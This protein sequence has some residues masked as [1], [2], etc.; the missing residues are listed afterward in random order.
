[1]TRVLLLVGVL[2]AVPAGA[3]ELF[4]AT[5]GS[6]GK[7]DGSL[8]SPFATISKAAS[9][10]RPGDTVLVRGGVYRQPVAVW[11]DGTEGARITFRPYR[12]ERP[13][14]DGGGRGI[15]AVTIGGDYV[16]WIGFEIRNSGHIGLVCWGAHHVRLLDNVVHRSVRAGIYVGHSEPYRVHDVEVAG[17]SVYDN[18]L[19]NRRRTWPYGNWA[20]AVAV[21]ESRRVTVRQNRV[22]RNFGEG[23]LAGDSKD[24]LI[25]ANEVFD[26]YSVQI[27][28]TYAQRT[29]VD[30]NRTYSTGNRS[31]YRNGRPADGIMLANEKE[32]K[33]SEATNGNSIVNNVV[34]RSRWGISYWRRTPHG[35]KNTR[36]ANNTI[37][38]A[39][40]YLLYID[41][42]PA[43]SGN[44]VENNIFRQRR[45]SAATMV[46]VPPGAA[47]VRN[48]RWTAVS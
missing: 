26:N 35:M 46:S 19:E 15:D 48:N 37:S 11:N 41:P 3:A 21:F 23:I 13:I 25:A 30:G 12:S 7:G 10:A 43:H 27:Y 44:L 22:F 36:I 33:A 17:N 34:G 42:D 18:V 20:A 5:N 6:D 2:L 14:I 9:A 38:D 32:G 47:T 24:C 39:A 45:S 28:L 40:E 8:R 16:D 29:V 1:M 4:V 31:Y